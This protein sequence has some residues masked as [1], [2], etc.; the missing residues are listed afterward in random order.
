MADLKDWL[1]TDWLLVIS[2]IGGLFGIL[3]FIVLFGERIRRTVSPMRVK[4]NPPT[5]VLAWRIAKSKKERTQGN[6][7]WDVFFLN[8]QVTNEGRW[9][10][11]ETHNWFTSGVLKGCIGR[12]KIIGVNDIPQEFYDLNWG[13][14]PQDWRDREKLYYHKQSVDE[15]F[16]KI[17]DYLSCRHMDI[18]YGETGSKSL[19]LLHA[20]SDHE[21]AY[22]ATKLRFRVKIPAKFRIQ[23]YIFGENLRRGPFNYEVEIKSWNQMS[24]TPIDC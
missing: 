20:I 4:I 9:Y 21:Y 12:V 14:I 15:Y 16:D 2:L 5:P 3:D 23:L 1:L 22:F 10:T 17:S 18:E 19:H 8:F 7:R 24:T 13:Y 11:Y 6:F